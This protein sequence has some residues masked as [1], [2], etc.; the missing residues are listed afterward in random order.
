MDTHI[1][2]TCPQCTREFI[3]DIG[4]SRKYTEK[5]HKRMIADIE[6]KLAEAIDR[7]T[8]VIK[9]LH[10]TILDISLVMI[11]ELINKKSGE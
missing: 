8:A 11:P 6:T 3:V 9:E 7:N 5:Y 2:V 10:K 1:K 4:M